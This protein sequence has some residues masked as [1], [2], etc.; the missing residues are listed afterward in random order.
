LEATSFYFLPQ[1]VIVKSYLDGVSA[2]ELA[3]EYNTYAATITKILKRHNVAIRGRWSD[4][5]TFKAH[6]VFND[7]DSVQKL[8]ALGWYT[9]DGYLD[10]SKPVVGIAINDGEIANKL[11]SILEYNG[12][13]TRSGKR[14]ILQIRDKS[15]YD[16]LIS[17][18]VHPVKS[19]D[20]HIIK[21]IPDSHWCDFIRGVFEGDGNFEVQYES[22]NSSTVKHV[23]GC[24]ITSYSEQFCVQIRDNVSRILGISL[25]IDSQPG[26]ILIRNRDS[27]LP[28]YRW[29]YHD[30]MKEYY[31]S[32]KLRLAR[33][34]TSGVVS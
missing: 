23:Y 13:I 21:H 9:S 32:R 7:S 22:A 14:Y 33:I 10:S 31:L 20:V 16:S 12:N 19:N 2:T 8:W 15:I 11:K 1:D 30:D 4:L 3:R 27:Y 34:A 17:Y 25:D 28:F 6:N 5:N 29:I 24:C 18:G 26:R